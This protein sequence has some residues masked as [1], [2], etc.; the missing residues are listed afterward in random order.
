M[1]GTS[2][3]AATRA[4]ADMASWRSASPSTAHFFARASM[5]FL[6]VA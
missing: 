1:A 5:A 2:A 3:G 6:A 4:A